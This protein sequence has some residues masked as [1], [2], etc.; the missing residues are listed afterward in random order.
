MTKSTRNVWFAR[1][2]RE[3]LEEL[4]FNHAAATSPAAQGTPARSPAVSA[5]IATPSPAV[6][7]R[8]ATPSDRPRSGTPGTPSSS[9]VVRGSPVCVSRGGS[10]AH[11]QGRSRPETGRLGGGGGHNTPADIIKTKSKEKEWVPF[12]RIFW[13]LVMVAFL[14]YI[15]CTSGV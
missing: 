6:P 2:D 8:T 12:Y 15:I 5:R 1:L 14:D 13:N 9:P 4:A 3:S 11:E 10:P 7:A